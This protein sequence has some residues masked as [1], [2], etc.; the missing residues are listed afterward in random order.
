MRFHGIML[1]RDDEDIIGECLAHALKWCDAIY[2]YD[3]GSTD[4]TWEIVN[5]FALKN[6]QVVPFKHERPAMLLESGLRGYVF[7]QFRDRAKAGDWFAQIDTDEFFHVL[8]PDFVRD[9]LRRGETGVYNH[10]FEFRITQSE[11]AKFE[12]G[13]PAP[14]D[15]T[16]PIAEL[17]RHYNILKHSEPRMFRYRRGMQWEPTE[18]YPW[19]M[20]FVARA[21][22]P[23]RHYPHRDPI[24][25]QQRSAMRRLMAPL[26]SANWTHWQ[27]ADWREFLADDNDP[28]LHYWRPGDELTPIQHRKAAPPLKR[29][30][31]WIAHRF[32]LPILDSRRPKYPADFKPQII[33]LDLDAKI[34]AALREIGASRPASPRRAEGRSV[35]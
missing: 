18:P 5:E 33:P 11:L 25:L 3:T 32:L 16:R 12:A 28:E 17:R 24:Q 2:V 34:V 13:D 15:R 29:T 14:F 9:H 6:P 1:T 35:Y 10:L 26:A 22:V 20:G 8:P 30:A 21:R 31:Q 27:R 19:N 23:I 4:R 7:Q